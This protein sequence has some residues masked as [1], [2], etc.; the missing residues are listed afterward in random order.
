M[1]LMEHS[2]SYSNGEFAIVQRKTDVR[3][4]GDVRDD[5]DDYLQSL[6]VPGSKYVFNHPR[7]GTAYTEAQLSNAFSALR[8]ALYRP[9]GK[10]LVMKSLRHSFVAMQV[11]AQT[12]PFDI[13]E[14][15]GHK[16]E[17]LYKIMERYSLRTGAG[18]QR[19]ARSYNRSIGGS[20]A[21]FSR[22]AQRK[23]EFVTTARPAMTYRGGVDRSR[24][25]QFAKRYWEPREVEAI[26]TENDPTVLA[27]L[28]ALAGHR[29]Q[30][31][32]Y[33]EVVDQR[34]S[35]TIEPD[36]GLSTPESRS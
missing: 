28:A 18:A 34:L 4:G 2:K 6:R 25:R 26:F 17:T 24:L 14:M 16:H 10:W 22:V 20:D 11:E 31:E 36:D 27:E 35:A 32:R 29:S 21:D 7:T 15:T 30:G 5:V 8:R 9:G 12:H 13:A 19:A 33:A 3:V 1:R 23:P